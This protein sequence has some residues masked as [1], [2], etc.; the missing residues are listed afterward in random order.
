LQALGEVVDAIVKNLHEK[1]AIKSPEV[2][3]MPVAEASKHHHGLGK[4]GVEIAEVEENASGILDG[5]QQG[6]VSTKVSRR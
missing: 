2:E 5:S 6:R 4:Y 3:R 1:G